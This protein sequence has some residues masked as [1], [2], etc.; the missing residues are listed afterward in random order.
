MPNSVSHLFLTL[1]QG[2]EVV[3]HKELTSRKMDSRDTANTGNTN[4]SA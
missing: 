3:A 1:V 2:C 4:K